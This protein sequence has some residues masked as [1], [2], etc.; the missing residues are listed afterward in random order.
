MSNRLFVF[1]GAFP[2]EFKENFLE[3]EVIY[4]KSHFNEVTFIPFSG[5]GTKQRPLPIGVKVDNRLHCSR[6][7]KILLGLLNSEF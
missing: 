3:Q 4:L 6:R 5:A 1:T 2:Y 7:K